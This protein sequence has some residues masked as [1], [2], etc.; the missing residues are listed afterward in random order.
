MSTA[1]SLP[2]PSSPWHPAQEELYMVRPNSR[3]TFEPS[4]ELC[5]ASEKGMMKTQSRRQSPGNRNRD[6]RI[7]DMCWRGH[8]ISGLGRIFTTT[9]SKFHAMEISFD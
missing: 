9:F 1:L 4:S 8:S 5:R 3:V 7:G 6:L 2:L